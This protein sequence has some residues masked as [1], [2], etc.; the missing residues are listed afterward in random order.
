[1]EVHKRLG[2][3]IFVHEKEVYEQYS[4]ISEI[5]SILHHDILNA[6]V[7]LKTK[8]AAQKQT[9][10]NERN[11]LDINFSA[12]YFENW[13]E[14]HPFSEK[15]RNNFI[16]IC[17]ATHNSLE[18]IQNFLTYLQPKKVYLNVVPA[19]AHEKMKMFDELKKIERIYKKLDDEEVEKPKTVERK[20]SFKRLRSNHS[21]VENDAK[22]I[23]S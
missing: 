7:F 10:I 18:E 15:I 12:M 22:K 9:A 3:K 4:Q 5:N 16:R 21:N 20:F 2:E 13:R 8:Y 11:I 23:K 14:G 6:R 19:Q 17:Y 1:M